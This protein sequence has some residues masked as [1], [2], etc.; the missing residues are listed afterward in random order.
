[1]R[2]THAAAPCARARLR[3]KLEL[4]PFHGWLLKNTF[5]VAMNGMPSRED[6]FER[7]GP[8][9][10][11]QPQETRERLVLREVGECDVMLRQVIDSMRNLFEELGLEDMRKV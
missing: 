3:Y 5:A 6:V 9:L 4:E 7:L 11:H 8:H 10:M 2:T 1:M